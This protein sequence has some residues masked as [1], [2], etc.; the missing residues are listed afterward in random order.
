MA[1]GNARVF[2]RSNPPL[3]R[4]AEMDCSLQPLDVKRLK[5]LQKIGFGVPEFTLAEG[6]KETSGNRQ[7]DHSAPAPQAG[8]GN[9]SGQRGP[10]DLAAAGERRSTSIPFQHLTPTFL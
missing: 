8:C 7:N 6:M 10:F 3:A 1:T 4:P 5:K 9:C 2:A